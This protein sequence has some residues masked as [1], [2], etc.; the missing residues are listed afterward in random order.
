VVGLH[1]STGDLDVERYA[2]VWSWREIVH[3]AVK[4]D[5]GCRRDYGR[6]L[7]RER[8]LSGYPARMLKPLARGRRHLGVVRMGRAGDD[9]SWSG[10]CPQPAVHPSGRHLLR[11]GAY[12]PVANPCVPRC[13]AQPLSCA[14]S[15]WKGDTGA[16]VKLG[17]RR[18]AGQAQRG[19]CQRGKRSPLLPPSRLLPRSLLFAAARE[20]FGLG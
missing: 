17:N 12:V 13:C 4:M 19:D 3:G 2:S 15:A 1:S 9:A 8:G 10:Q 7:V 14:L 16:G 18:P 6:V 11:E 5:L 20:S